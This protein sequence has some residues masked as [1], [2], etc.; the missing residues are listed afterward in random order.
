MSNIIIIGGEGGGSSSSSSS[1]SGNSKGKASPV[2]AWRGPEYSRKLR[3]P[4]FNT[5]GT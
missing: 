1:S 2:Q 4:D 3:L 5:I